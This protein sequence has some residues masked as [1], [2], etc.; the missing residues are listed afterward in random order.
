MSEVSQLLVSPGPHLWKKLSVSKI[1]YLVVIALLF[2]TGAAI[3]F[4]G[5]N[6]L[7]V[8]GVSVGVAVLTEY[9]CKKLMGRVF[10]M[11]GSAVVTGLLLALVLPP[12]IPLWM[13]ALGAVFA[14]AIVKEAFGGLGH[15]IFNPA[16][17]ARAFMSIS[18]PLQMTSWVA[19]TRLAADA[20][21][22]ATPLGESFI[23]TADR[24]SLYQTMF[25]GNTA[26]SLGETSTLLI[27]VGGIFLIGRGL[28]NWRIPAV[29]IGMVAL[30]SFAMGQDPLFHILAGGL[31][32]G[33]FFMATDYVTSPLTNRG[34]IVFALALGVLTMLIRRFAGMPE[35][36]CYSILFMNA[37]TPLI[38]RYIKIRPY[39]L[40]QRVKGAG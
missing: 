27:L 5:H 37:M 3:Y 26:G 15:N 19:P 12:L 1:M 36:V 23:W 21:T 35:G 28:I 14:I 40:V 38:D 18:F 24:L 34:K 20:I 30:L 32:I 4:F 25:L 22:T 9:L 16:L 29:Y 17:A 2:P 13:V 33:A 6:A 31:M 10:I 11:D 8:I 39:G 7:S